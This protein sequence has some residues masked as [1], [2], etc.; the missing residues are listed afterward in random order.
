MPPRAPLP[1]AA[2]PGGVR[3][4]WDDRGGRRLGAGGGG[5]LG[6]WVRGLCG[7]VPRRDRAGTGRGLTPLL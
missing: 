4:P 6:T 3:D 7:P 1:P 2:R 5:G